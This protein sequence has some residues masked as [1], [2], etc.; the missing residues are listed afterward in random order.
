[1]TDQQTQHPLS[2][3]DINA[4]NLALLNRE[5]FYSAEDLALCARPHL[6][7][8]FGKEIVDEL[9]LSLIR[10]GLH[11]AQARSEKLAAIKH[12]A[13]ATYRLEGATAALAYFIDAVDHL[14][15]ST[16]EQ[17]EG[18]KRRVAPMFSGPLNTEDLFMRTIDAAIQEIFGKPT[19]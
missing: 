7:E 9:E 5:G 8:L 17:D 3:L 10:L 12:M 2:D 15:A 18:W 11:V 19:A 16:A 4:S 13:G 14:L 1:L 6:E